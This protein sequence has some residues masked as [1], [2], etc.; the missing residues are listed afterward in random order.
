MGLLRPPRDALGAT[1]VTALNQY[2]SR[3]TEQRYLRETKREPLNGLALIFAQNTLSYD[4]TFRRRE[5]RAKRR[6]LTPFKQAAHTSAV[7]QHL[8]NSALVSGG[9]LAAY[10]AIDGELDLWSFIARHPRIALPV[11]ESTK[12][13]SF[14]AYRFGDR[15]KINRFGIP[16]PIDGRRVDAM[17]LS[18]VL[19]P[20]V[21]FDDN[22]T[23]IGMGGGYYDLHFARRRRPLLIGVGHA[24]QHVKHI[25]QREKDVPLDA[26][27]TE[28][29]WYYF[30]RRAEKLK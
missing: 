4:V 21:G 18:A 12:H 20:L 2:G 19:T 10:A 24:L 5:L 7:S 29:G 9:Y 25:P 8:F 11:V 22:G 14:R 6:T 17:K 26:V 28:S 15:L 30:S 23:R 27:V 13:M 16:E 3:P 1:R